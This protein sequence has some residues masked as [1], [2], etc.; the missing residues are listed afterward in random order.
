M[1][2]LNR[3]HERVKLPY[4]SPPMTLPTKF[5][6]EILKHAHYSCLPDQFLNRTTA[7][8]ALLPLRY[9]E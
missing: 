1:R 7:G 4:E 5:R 3:H 2:D 6:L 9:C 8:D